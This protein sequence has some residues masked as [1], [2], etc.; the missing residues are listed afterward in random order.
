MHGDNS[1]SIDGLGLVTLC[2]LFGLIINFAWPLLLSSS[3]RPL[4]LHA[5]SCS[6]DEVSICP[7][8]NLAYPL[9]LLSDRLHRSQ[10]AN[11]M[12]ESD[13]LLVVLPSS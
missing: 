8:R 1:R 6:L 12:G 5:L 10:S 4:C 11:R 3:R 9:S 7:S 2:F 13:T